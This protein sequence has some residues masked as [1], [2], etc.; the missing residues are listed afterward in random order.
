MTGVKNLEI[1]SDSWSKEFQIIGPATRTKP[2]SLRGECILYTNAAA[3]AKVF[4]CRELLTL[5]HLI[6]PAHVRYS[7]SHNHKDV[8]TQYEPNSA[9]PAQRFS[10][11]DPR[12]WTDG[13]GYSLCRMACTATPLSGLFD[14][15]VRLKPPPQVKK[16]NRLQTAPAALTD[17]QSPSSYSILSWPAMAKPVM[18]L[19]A[20]K[21]V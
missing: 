21:L 19:A 12:G 10:H 5:T 15:K 18:T 11:T 14:Y 17:E 8:C 7:K 9:K 6:S 13:H 16:D 3:Q 20:R 1:S 2:C 4:H